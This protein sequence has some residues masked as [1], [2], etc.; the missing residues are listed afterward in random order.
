MKDRENKLKEIKLSK[1]KKRNSNEPLVPREQEKEKESEEV[2][3]P[4]KNSPSYYPV[5][6]RA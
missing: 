2:N 6:G 5:V 1:T 4:T 3:P